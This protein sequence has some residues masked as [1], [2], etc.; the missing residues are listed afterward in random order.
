M[1]ISA[2]IICFNEEHNIR[3]CLE[4]VLWVDEI[5]VVDSMSR[6]TTVEIARRFTRA[7]FERPWE[8]YA[9]QKNFALSRASSDW[10]LSLD[11]DEEV[12]P[13]LREEIQREL[14]KAPNECA[15]YRIPRLSFYQG[16][17][18][19]HS[20]F[21]PDR[22]LRLFRRELGSW[23]GGR[24]HERVEV[25]GK[26]CNLKHDLL[27]YPYKGTIAGQLD[28]VNSFSTLLAEDM[29]DKGKRYRLYLLVFRPL[30]KFAEVYLLKRGFLDGFA[31]L[32]I[33]VTAAYG[34][35]VRY[36]KLREIEAHHTD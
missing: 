5:I 28:T 22:Q 4:S 24:V 35:F 10:V 15:G 32:F 25:K 17:W 26:V 2:C 13:E 1:S 33:A 30:F 12:T 6:D 11:A 36:V 34:M 18:I 29:Y 3:R 8:G 27:H 14:A 9:S 23:V 20:G 16:R 7:V 21:Y 31:G 19:K